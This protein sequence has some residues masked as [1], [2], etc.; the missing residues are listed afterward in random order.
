M[1][2]ELLSDSTVR[3]SE[4]AVPLPEVELGEMLVVRVGEFCARACDGGR[5][6]VMR[7]RRMRR[8][9]E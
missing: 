1:S 9:D 7:R 3:P 2:L 5:S 6:S 8:R 4:P